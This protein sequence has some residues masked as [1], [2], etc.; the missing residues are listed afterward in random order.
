MFKYWFLV[1]TKAALCLVEWVSDLLFGSTFTGGTRKERDKARSSYEASAHLVRVL[2]RAKYA[3]WEVRNCRLR[4][5]LYAHESYV[6][7]NY[8]LQNK[9]VSLLAVE[10]DYALFCVTDPQV[11]LFDVTKFPFLVLSQFTESRKLVVLP[12]KS[13]HRLAE[14]VGDPKVPVGM[15]HMTARCGSTL[16]T[17]MIYRVPGTRAITECWSIHNLYDLLCRSHVTG[18]E[19]RRLLRSALRLHCNNS[20]PEE[21]IERVFMKMTIMNAPQFKDIAELF[22]QF[23]FIFNTRHPVPS[24]KSHIQAF[25]DV[26]TEDLY[27]RL[28]IHW[29]DVMAMGLFFPRT[30]KYQT[31]LAQYSSWWPPHDPL[32]AG[33]LLYYAPSL[34]CYFENK[35]MYHQV[36]LYE[37]ISED[38]ETEPGKMLR[39]MGVQEELIQGAVLGALEKDSQNATFGKWKKGRTNVLSPDILRRTDEVMA[40]CGIPIRHDMS[41][42]EFKKVFGK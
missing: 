25:V 17:Q 40:D 1:T 20:H 6:H 32:E 12:V 15:V 31:L 16:L 2:W 19:Y 10:K 33:G 36:I 27:Y 13:F 30:P 23:K 7:P 28:G 11:D 39:I 37:D 29:R 22:P 35:D 9:N 38:P 5:F 18:E 14:E 34:A 42:E 4:N 8:V 41:V 21:Q 24:L 26:Q 3:P